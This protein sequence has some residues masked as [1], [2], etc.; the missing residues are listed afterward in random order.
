MASATADRAPRNTAQIVIERLIAHGIDTLYCLPGVQNDAFFDALFAETNRLRPIHTRH[1]QGAAYMALGAAMATGKPAA[2]CVVPGPGF[3]NTSAALSQAYGNNAPV[4]A[5]CGQIPLAYVNRDTGFLHD[6]PDQLGI[7]QRL[8]K[9]SA[10]ICAP[11]E[12]AALTDEAFR[13]MLAG[14]PRP[15]ALE[16][17]LDVW[18]RAAPLAMPGLPAPLPVPQPDDDAIAAAAK[19]LGQSERPLIVVGGGASGAS[20]EVTLLAEM[21]E[22][23]V[24][25]YRMGHGVVDARHELSLPFPAG[26]KLWPE[27]DVVI[28]IGTRLHSQYT[29]WGVDDTLKLIRVEIDPQEMV[30]HGRPTLPLLGDA[31]AVVRRLLDAIPKHN[32]KRGD[33]K[34]TIAAVK[35]QTRVALSKLQPQL[36]YLEA[37]RAELP[38]DGIFVD[39]FT[40][41]GYVSRLAYPVY[42]PRT[43]LTLG[44]QGALG[45]GFP[46]ALGAK[47]ARPEV[48]VVSVNGDGGFMFNVQELATAVQFRI[49]VVSIVFNDNAYGNVRR[50]QQ[51]LYGGRLIASDL[52]NPDFVRLAESFG[53]VGLRAASPAEL[54]VQL[55]RGMKE[56]GPVLIE[57]PIGETPAPWEFIQLPRVRPPRRS[58]QT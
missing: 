58:R 16:C 49:P 31:Q 6:I 15:A 33:F 30:R 18:G 45:M 50:M 48:P 14:R 5:V 24:V 17:P 28:G 42:A 23:P 21:L 56:A 9:W 25:A 19:A 7:M 20:R 44:Y 3:L 12:A 41:V 51:D 40:Q 13:Q 27:V 11:H 2:Y 34:D 4:L 8:T 52:K 37:I 54:R 43:Y 57:V 36:A 53:A 38:E 39:E 35:A 10:R 26:H 47:V 22:A 1:E 46:T 29:G 32:R 55:R